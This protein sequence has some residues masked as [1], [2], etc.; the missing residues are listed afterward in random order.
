MGMTYEYQRMFNLNLEKGRYYTQSEYE[1][2][3]HKIIIG[4]AI[5][6]SL[7]GAIEPVGK[8]VKVMGRN[9]QVVGVLEKSGEALINP[10]DYDNSILI[11]YTLAKQMADVRLRN[12]PWGTQLNIKAKG[13]YSIDELK[14]EVTGVLRAHRRLKPKEQDDFSLNEVSMITNMLDAVFKVLNLA[15]I[16]IGLFAILVGMFSVANIM[17]VSVKERTNIIGIKKAL[18]A[19]RYFILLEFLIEAI[20]LCILGG[21]VG[22]LLVYA[23]MLIL[24]K[25][26]DFNLYLS[27]GNV[28]IGLVLSVA[29]GVLAGLIP[30]NQASR[31][32]P[33][34]AM[35]H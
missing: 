27:V 4:H 28:L 25:V 21:L 6:E 35:W 33:V 1:G 31:M 14:D 24:T 12:N 9:L 26:L 32:D 3:S 30:A 17:F 20:V 10:F 2:G 8:M 15:G 16:L 7:F 22:L 29:I 11:P 34:E 5:A 13:G 23:S 19:K 18:G